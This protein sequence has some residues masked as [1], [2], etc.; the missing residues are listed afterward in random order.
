MMPFRVTLTESMFQTHAGMCLENY[1][2]YL[3]FLPGTIERYTVSGGHE[4][5]G[6]RDMEN[7]F[8]I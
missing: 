2:W 3:R 7:F 5:P 6:K 8:R 4:I 1:S